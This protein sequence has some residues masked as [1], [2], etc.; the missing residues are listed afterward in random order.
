LPVSA[1]REVPCY[2]CGR[3]EADHV[4]GHC[5]QYRASAYDPAPSVATFDERLSGGRVQ[6]VDVI[7]GAA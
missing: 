5:G 3:R 2:D 4:D 7:G 1:G 6:T